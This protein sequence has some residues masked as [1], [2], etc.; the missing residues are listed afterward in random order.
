MDALDDWPVS[1]LATLRPAFP[2]MARSGV[3]TFLAGRVA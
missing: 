3:D 2:R 1:G